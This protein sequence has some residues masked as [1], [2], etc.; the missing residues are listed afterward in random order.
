MEYRLDLHMHSNSSNDGEFSPE[1]L[2]ELCSEAHLK[3]VAVTDHNSV[4][5]VR[6]AEVA[7][8][9]F[10]MKLIAGVELDCRYLGCNLHLLG[11]GIDA[12]AEIFAK[13]ETTVHAQEKQAS[14]QYMQLIKNLGI[15]FDDKQVMKLAARGVVTAEMLAEVALSDRR[16]DE[17]IL[18][19]PY[20]SGGS[21]SD[22][23]YVNF[24]W[25]FCAQGKAAHVPMQFME[26][27]EAVKIIHDTGGAAVWAHPG[28]NVGV[29]EKLAEGI[30]DEGIDGIEVYSSYHDKATVEF[31]QKKCKE[32]D[33]L[34]T[35]GSDFHGATK[36][37]IHL[38]KM[39]MEKESEMLSRLLTLIHDRRE[40]NKK[41]DL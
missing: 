16:N 24:Y 38:G 15:V 41:S 23:P 26:L 20:R 18:L 2:M 6:Y 25:D 40:H 4:S 11:Y 3:T 27:R 8:N 7:A 39:G 22:N 12:S 17:N 30:I 29:D 35:I 37:A 14:R 21:R 33:L 31:Y 9:K 34:E 28:A 1:Q 5:G 32:Y 13:I 19:Q 36:P 10:G